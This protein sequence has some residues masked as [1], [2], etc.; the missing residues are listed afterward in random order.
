[1]KK[2]IGIDLGGTNIKGI[3]IDPNGQVL[4]QHYI[5]TQDTADG[6][7]RAN[8]LEM[9][10]YLQN[11]LQEPIAAV[12]M[13]APGL[14]DAENSCIQ[15]LPN[16]LPGLEN[17]VWADYLGHTTYILNDAHAALMAEASFGA[18]RGYRHAL[19]LTLGTGVGG[20]L[21]INGQ[22]Y[23][24]LGQMAGHL[25]HIG[26]NASDDESSIVGMVG[27]LEY[28]IGNYSIARRSRGAFGSTWE[29][30]EAYRK[31]EHWA[32]FVW[33][34]S[35]QQLAVALS[36]LVNA[37]SPEVIVLSGGITLAD[38][39]LYGPLADF[40]KQYEWRPGTKQTPIVQAYFGDMS[41]AIGAASFALQKTATH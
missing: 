11:W 12:G 35:V 27:S 6:S 26:L 39:A 14:P 5:A 10:Q 28:A 22:L 7:W 21:L 4:K 2:Y 15:Y 9:V 38:E 29:L 19:L 41:G 16:R 25:G 3:V 17:F 20:G 37:F 13:S 33:L 36:S 40:M 23:Q 8:V 31:G 30:V 32:T 18:A 1:M 34:R 24:G